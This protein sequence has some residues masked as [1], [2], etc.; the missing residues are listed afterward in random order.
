L[1][2]ITLPR[3]VTSFPAP[4]GMTLDLVTPLVYA[5]Q[6]DHARSVQFVP[7]CANVDLGQKRRI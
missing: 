1:N 7:L 4:A 6:T 2:A 5:C 3:A